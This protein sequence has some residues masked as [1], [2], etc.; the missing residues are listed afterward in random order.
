MPTKSLF[1]SVSALSPEKPCG[2]FQFLSSFS[3]TSLYFSSSA[4]LPWGLSSQPTSVFESQLLGCRL[5]L[6]AQRLPSAITKTSCVS[7]SWLL[8]IW[9]CRRLFA[10][11]LHT[12]GRQLYYMRKRHETYHRET[13]F[14]AQSLRSTGGFGKVK[15]RMISDNCLSKSDLFLLTLWCC[16]NSFW[17]VFSRG[18][19][20][21]FR[22]WNT[23][24]N[25]SIGATAYQCIRTAVPPK[26]LSGKI[27]P[28][29]IYFLG[30][31]NG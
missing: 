13:K 15:N 20:N 30:I 29:G 11:L 22:Y 31:Q 21:S 27:V 8:T 10:Y 12:S 14:I 25:L 7:D 3:S 9:A 4:F 1:S 19:G 2:A 6:S 24:V 16:V 5:P 17:E 18:R 26:L 23:I 28:P